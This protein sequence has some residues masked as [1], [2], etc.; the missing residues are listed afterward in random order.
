MIRAALAACLL[1]LTQAGAWAQMDYVYGTIRPL[2]AKDDYVHVLLDEALTRTS[3]KYGAYSIKAVPELPRTRQVRA[4]ESGAGSIT[5]AIFGTAHEVGKTLRP[6]LIP[7]DKGLVGYRLMLVRCSQQHRFDAIRS[8]ADLKPLSFGQNFVWDDVDILKANGLAVQSGE[9]FEGLFQM[10]MR[11]RFD[12]FPRGI[13]EINRELAEHAALYP[14]LC[15]EKG[16]MIH[17]PLPVYFWFSRNA[18]GEALAARLEEGLRAM[19]ADGSFDAIFW[20]YNRA[21]LQ[22]LGLEHRRVL[23]LA[24]PLLPSDTPL[25]DSRLWLGPGQLH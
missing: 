5:L 9:D 8:A 11:N 22:G 12:A 23:E 3:A 15:I 14:D 20:K 10:L 17:Y 24:N 25:S 19:L 4:L 7:V 1:L 16:L 21:A 18:K 2:D 13:G 6:I